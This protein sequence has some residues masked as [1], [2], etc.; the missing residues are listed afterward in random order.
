MMLMLVLACFSVVVR[1]VCI[2]LAS[3]LDRYIKIHHIGVQFSR[4]TPANGFASLALDEL[5]LILFF[6]RHTHMTYGHMGPMQGCL[7]RCFS[8]TLL[9]RRMPVLVALQ[10]IPCASH[11][12]GRSV[13]MLDHV[14]LMVRAH[15]GL[16]IGGRH[17]YL[18]IVISIDLTLHELQ[19]SIVS[20]TVTVTILQLYVFAAKS[21]PKSPDLTL[22]S[23]TR[24]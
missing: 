21:G 2:K 10:R 19:G 3:I 12:S 1:T 11:A 4:P 6:P 8:S 17:F 20:V 22:D 5:R 9:P 13:Q 7:D 16:V 14:F 23:K 15:L 18:S 24:L